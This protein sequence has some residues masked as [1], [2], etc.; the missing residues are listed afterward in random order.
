MK[1]LNKTFPNGNGKAPLPDDDEINVDDF[2]WTAPSSHPAP[3]AAHEGFDTVITADTFTLTIPTYTPERLKALRKRL[4]MN[5]QEFGIAVGYA[6]NGAKQRISELENARH[7][8]PQSVSIIAGYLERYG[9]FTPF[10][11]SQLSV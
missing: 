8:I 3:N 5:A 4:G 11:K 6:A 7:P 10:P 9:V 2:D 1:T